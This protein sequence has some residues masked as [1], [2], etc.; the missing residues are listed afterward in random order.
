MCQV[1]GT[2]AAHGATHP[3]LMWPAPWQL[4]TMNWTMLPQDRQ[5]CLF[6]KPQ[7]TRVWDP[8]TEGLLQIPEGLE[9]CGTSAWQ[10][11]LSIYNDLSDH[12]SNCQSFSAWKM[13]QSLRVSGKATQQ[14]AQSSSE[15]STCLY[16]GTERKIE[17]KESG[18]WS[19]SATKSSIRESWDSAAA[20]Y[21]LSTQN[22]QSHQ[23]RE[24]T[25]E[26]KK[27]RKKKEFIHSQHLSEGR[28]FVNLQW[29]YRNTSMKD[30]K[31][32]G[33]ENG[34]KIATN[35]AYAFG[36]INFMKLAI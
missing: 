2:S 29:I 19:L 1:L 32:R 13:S 30:F 14:C 36:F 24:R 10:S 18:F 7:K 15:P 27:E 35:A 17:I 34:A 12:K 21:P 16:T 25:E 23:R 4:G 20:V 8:L 9:A 22:Q 31:C 3:L 28:G 26:K 5:Q 11:T 6:H 33:A